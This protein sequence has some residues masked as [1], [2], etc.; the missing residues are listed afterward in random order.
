MSGTSWCTA[1]GETMKYLLFILF[2]LS[3]FLS[4]SFPGVE[5]EVTPWYHN[6]EGAL[7]VTFD[8]C[9]ETQYLV[10]APIIEK[11]DIRGTFGVVTSWVGKMVEEPKGVRIQ[12]MTWKQIQELSVTH[13][14]ASHTCTHPN[15]AMLCKE[16][17][18]TEIQDSKRLIEEH[19]RKEC[20]AMHY[21]LSR[22]NNVVKRTLRDSGYLCA[23]SYENRINT[24]PDLYEISSYAIFSDNDPSLGDL[25]AMIRETRGKN[26][27]M[28]LM[29][30][31]ISN[32]PENYSVNA[33]VPLCVTPETFEFQMQLLSS[34]DLWIAPL[35]KVATY[36]QQRET[37][38]IDVIPSFGYVKIRVNTPFDHPLTI[39]VHHDWKEVKVKGSLSDSV[40][41]TDTFYLDVQ[42]NTEIIL[43]RVW[44]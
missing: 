17:L 12:K 27:W 26:G 42:P 36:I 18:L 35:G 43:Y 9:D 15:L 7:S 33:S 10:A 24:D 22:T 8:D 40:Y 11:Y 16:A 13:E 32:Y 23:R 41:T 25:Q 3:S 44:P 2:V 28:V 37:C 31:H 14:I 6:A 19:T 30:H 29:Y 21:P 38:T 20:I 1:I 4:P 39:R 34:S 5:V